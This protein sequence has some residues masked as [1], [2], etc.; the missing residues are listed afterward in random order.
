[1]FERL[2]PLLADD[3]VVAIH[4][5]GTVPRALLGIPD[6][7]WLREVPKTWV[8]DEFEHQPG[9]RAFVNWLLAAHPEFAQLHVHSRRTIRAGISLLQRSGAL[10]RPPD[11]DP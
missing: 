5:T 4:D 10:A 6:D 8:D 7:H 3:A 2:A 11:A 1:M 9:E